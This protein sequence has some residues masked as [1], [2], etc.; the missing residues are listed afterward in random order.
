M[1]ETQLLAQS[2]YLQV[3]IT[4]IKDRI[5]ISRDWLEVCWLR[6]QLIDLKKIQETSANAVIEIKT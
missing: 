5:R 2:D 6:H 3:K 1:P 4:L